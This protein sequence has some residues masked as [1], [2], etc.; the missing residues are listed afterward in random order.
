MGNV[1]GTMDLQRVRRLFLFAALLAMAAGA[2]PP[3]GAQGLARGE[4]V[5]ERARA[6]YDAAGIRSGGFLIFPSVE[7]R[8]RRESNIYRTERGETGDTVISVRPAIEAVSQWSNHKLVAR[9]G[10]NADSFADEDDENTTDWFMNADGRIDVTRDTN[11]DLR[12]SVEELHEDRGDPNA[13][14]SAREP[15]SYSRRGVRLGGFHRFNRVSLAFEGAFRRLDFDNG[16]DRAG[17]R[18]DQRDRDRDESEMMARAGYAAGVGY[19]AFVRATRYERRYEHHDLT[20]RDSEGWELAAGTDLDLGGIVVGE[21]FA[22]YRSQGYDDP[23]LLGISGLTLGGSVNWNVT[24]LTTINSFVRRTV[25]ETVIGG[26]PG[27]LAT[28]LDLGVDHEL[29]RNL[30]LSANLRLTTNDYEGIAREDDL[31]SFGFGGTYLGSRNLHADFGYRRESRDSTE[32]GV[33]YDNDVVYLN[34]RL[35]H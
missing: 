18:I 25:E 7:A 13:P 6:D 16:V 23:S 30:I 22:G 1:N 8:L 35:Q 11:L 15:L 4:T 19:E 26:S 21:I 5:R 20:D 31:L 27:F 10:A 28:V 34:L 14:H 9:A 12:L 33:D 2:A 3:S 17:N 29:L 32:G 24:P